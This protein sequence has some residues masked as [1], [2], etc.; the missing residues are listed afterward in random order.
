MH[1]W[2][3]KSS[4]LGAALLS[5]ALGAPTPNPSVKDG[6]PQAVTPLLQTSGPHEM[7]KRTFLATLGAFAA[8][9]ASALYDPKPMAFLEAGTGIW[10]GTLTYRDYQK[11][12]R[13]VTLKTAMTSSL[14]APDELALYYVF[15]DGP[16]KTVYS[17]ERMRFDLPGRQIIW[18]SGIAKPSRVDYR[19]TSSSEQ[20]GRS[21]LAFEAPQDGRTDK[22]SLEITKKNWLLTKHEASAGSEDILRSKYEFSKREACPLAQG[23]DPPR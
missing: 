11:P 8:S 10:S 15:D 19:I 2:A 13:M 14:V 7:H 20:E 22:Y 21:T 4:E 17:Y 9:P 16:G 5:S 18:N 1:E 12:D 6:V 3:G 23:V